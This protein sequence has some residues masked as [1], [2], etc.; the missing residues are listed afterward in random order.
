VCSEPDWREV[1]RRLSIVSCKNYWRCASGEDVH[2]GEMAS[3][4][5][6]RVESQVRAFAV[7]S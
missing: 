5:F 4:S 7:R 1:Y 3:S 2:L 6:L